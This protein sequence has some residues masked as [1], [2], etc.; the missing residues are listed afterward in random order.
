MKL[1]LI[2]L[3]GTSAL[4]QVAQAADKPVIAPV[5]AWVKTVTPAPI[6]AKADEMPIRLLLSDQQVLL[7][8]EGTE[9]V[10]GRT[11][12]Q[13]QTP[14]GLAA[15]NISIPWR[16]ETDTLTVHKLLIRRGDTVIDVL[17][18]GQ[19]FTVV[20]REQNLESATLDGVLT[21]NIQPEGLQV[22][23]TLEI[24]TSV[25][26]RDP[27]MKGHVEH[28]AGAWNGYPV[29]RAHLRVEWPS[30]MPLRLRATSALP[31]I[32]P[33]KAGDRTSTEMTLDGVQP[34]V[35]PKGAP[36]RYGM[37]RIVEMTD[38]ASWADL[39]ALM[40]PL[41]DKAAV[42]PAEGPLRTELERIRAQSPD[43]KVRAE[44]AL[45]L[46]QDRVRYVALQMGAGGYVPADAAESWSRRYGD[47]KGKTALLLALLH[48]M[49]ISADA[50]AVNSGG[51]DGIDQRLPMAGL[52]NHV[53]VRAQIA[54]RTYWMDGTRTG[55]TSLDRLIVPHF[56]W[57]LP[58]VATGATLVHMVP[59]PIDVPTN[60]VTIQIDATAGLAAPAPTRIETILR[61]DD[62]IATN[63][64]IASLAGDARD[65]MLREY[66]K[67]QYDFIEVKSATA[68]FDPKTGEDRLV[69]EGV[70]RMDWGGDSYTTDGTGVGYRADFTRD[71]SADK[72]APYTVDYPIFNRVRETILLPKGNGAFRPAAGI[73]VDQTIAGIAYRRHATLKD[74][75]FTIERSERSLVSEISAK[76]AIAAQATLRTLADTPAKLNKPL[77]YV[78]TDK[79]VAAAAADTPTSAYE[80][81]QRALLYVSR[82]M[83]QEAIADYGKAIELNPNNVWAMANRAITRIEM[84]DLAGAKEDLSRADKI[85]PNHGPTHLARGMIAERENRPKD[86][87]AAYGKVLE[88]DPTDLFALDR[89][90]RAYYMIGDAK[91]GMADRQAAVD[92]GIKAA[93]E[94]ANAYVDRSNLLIDQQRYAEAIKDLDHALSIEPGNAQA[95][96]NRAIAQAWSGNY[97]AAGKDLTAVE[98]IAPRNITAMR[99]RGLVAQRQGKDR[100]AITAYSKA[101]EI[102]P[103][104]IFALS[105]RA[106]SAYRLQ[107]YDSVLKDMATILAIQPRLIEAHMLRANTLLRQHKEAE[108]TAAVETMAAADPGNAYTQVA[109]ANFYYGMGKPA[110]AMKA[111]DRAIAAGAEG[112]IYLNRAMRRPK[113]D[114]AGR[115]ADFDAALRLEPDNEEAITGKANFLAE[116]GDLPGA[117]AVYSKLLASKP[118]QIDALVGRGMAYSRQGDAARADADF[119][120]AR[121]K[122]SQPTELNAM[123]WNKAT[124]GIALESA[125]ADCNA[126]LAKA[127]DAAT[128]D[129]RGLVQLRL[130][131]PDEAIVDYDKALARNDRNAS[132]LF[133]RAIAW[134]RKGDKA[135]SDADAAAA[136]KLR[137]DIEKTYA[138]YG[139]TR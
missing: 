64:M 50:V 30:A 32:K 27:V 19:T 133:G 113:S 41:Y 20:R 98:A 118:D 69:M 53:I 137:P 71:P 23:D 6:P 26:S 103:G 5:P 72:D 102:D 68:S 8:K 36:A 1:F 44:A 80:Y 39:G 22:G 88:Q 112:F 115:R 16:P 75:V 82:G 121:D 132:S 76:D 33:V 42:I 108:L 129:S 136:I 128:L 83:R 45:A 73:E 94:A 43:P 96:A 67:N 52:F 122:A 90:G 15:G 125:L 40:A 31:P 48:A 29:G 25:T 84:G 4:T 104:D 97:E 100:D 127:D 56:G 93:P 126:S 111:Y 2:A 92:A 24:A 60:D 81:G 119:R 57:G 99:A 114:V 86:A 18:S 78:V 59:P 101:L 91:R 28:M 34:L 105:H 47:C 21:A 130:N 9:T 117:I 13:I 61:G 58:L 38:Y 10:F 54:G 87:I 14:Q 139:V 120:H 134:A 135:K 63:A 131:H 70:A 77:G 37:G 51:G 116:T 17:A 89:R 123:C 74:N 138:D 55:D 46:V 95:L 49:D 110:E 7:D 109:A 66:W 3:V 85:D 124:A 35:A 11:V 79:E 62:A 12:I 65:R 107:E 106:E